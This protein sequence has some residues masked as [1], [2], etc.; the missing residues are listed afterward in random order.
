M[1]KAEEKA[2]LVIF[3]I[4]IAVVFLW[5]VIGWTIAAPAFRNLTIEELNQTF[6]AFG[7]FGIMFAS[8]ATPLGALL[9]A[10]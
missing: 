5:R 4:R 10:I 7:G 1:A 2:G 8:F 6:W 3:W 9:A